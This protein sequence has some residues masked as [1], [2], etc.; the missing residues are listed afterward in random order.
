VDAGA[1]EVVLADGE[2]AYDFLLLATGATHSYFGHHEWER[3]APGLKSLED[4]LLIRRRLLLA[5]ERAERET[6]A[7]RRTEWLTF[8]VIG[9][10]PTGVELAG[11][12]IELARYT[13]RHEFRRMD[14][15]GARVVLLEG[16][17]R[18]LPPYPPELSA[19]AR[20]QL[21]RLGVEVRTGAMV[22]GV[23]EEGVAIGGERLRARTVL[24]GAGVAASPLG[25]SLGAPL[26]KAGRVKVA[27]DLSVPG[28]PEVFVTGDLA[29]VV[30][31]G[32]P[33]P[34]VAPAAN[35]MGDQA[36][37]N[38][39]RLVRGQ[40]TRPFRYVDKGSLATIGRRAAVAE[41][42]GLKLWGLPAWLA[43][44]GIH[45]FFLI[46]FRNRIVVLFEWALAY[47]TH[48]RNAR[49]ILEP[50]ELPPEAPGAHAAEPPAPRA[51]AEVAH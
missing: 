2:V 6:D 34:G 38:V 29:S 25:R 39:L 19:K 22:T 4:A 8:V 43:W 21:E 45:I 51:A 44:L 32:K 20:E 23:D 41:V 36:A 12:L 40:P 5:F 48:Q 24:W 1:R 11:T 26:D 14:P 50:R 47:F 7:R 42:R 18:V 31:D 27:A 37:R 9:G 46:G 49:L 10:G 17:D 33:V 35:Q 28:H 13:L 3:F 16:L 30:Q 15:G